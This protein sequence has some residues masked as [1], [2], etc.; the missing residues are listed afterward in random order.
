MCCVR[1]VMRLSSKC[2]ISAIILHL[3]SRKKRRQSTVQI[4]PSEG[5]VNIPAR[6]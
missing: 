5:L 3:E 6:C 2:V 4:E 1:S